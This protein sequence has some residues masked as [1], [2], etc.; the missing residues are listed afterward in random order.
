MKF[1]LVEWPPLS[2]RGLSGVA[3][4]AA[5]ALIA[6]MQHQSLAVPRNMRLRLMLVSR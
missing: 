2:S 5:L 3:G 4:A 1:L 6:M